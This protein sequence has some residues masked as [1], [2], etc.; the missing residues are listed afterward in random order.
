MVNCV[1]NKF[2]STRRSEPVE[3]PA[4]LIKDT[5]PTGDFHAQEE[6]RLFYVG[7]TGARALIYFTS[8]ED[9]GGARGW[10]VSQFVLEAL[11]LPKEAARPVR[12]RAIEELIRHAPPPEGQA[13]G[14]SR[15]AP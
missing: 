3:M 11:A 14:C 7:M 15:F 8:A 5:L 1:Q 2:P 13:G 4:A 6:R 12:A 9:R 10:K